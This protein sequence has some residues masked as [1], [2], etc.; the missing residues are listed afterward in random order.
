MF[1]REMKFV[2]VTLPAIFRNRV[3]GKNS[4]Q[5]LSVGEQI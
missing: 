3:L 5:V 1:M 2:T 4:S